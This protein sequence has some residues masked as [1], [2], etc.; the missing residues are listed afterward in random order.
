MGKTILGPKAPKS[1]RKVTGLPLFATSVTSEGTGQAEH[2]WTLR[3]LLPVPDIIQLATPI[4]P[5]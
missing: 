3:L 4:D 2:H 5:R 1:G